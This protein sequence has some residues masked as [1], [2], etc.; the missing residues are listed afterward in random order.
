MPGF[1]ASFLLTSGWHTTAPFLLHEWIAGAGAW[2]RILSAHCYNNSYNS[3]A[4]M[5]SHYAR[6]FIIHALPTSSYWTPHCPVIP[7]WQ[8]KKQRLCRR[9]RNEPQSPH[10]FV[11]EASFTPRSLSQSWWILHC[12]L[13]PN[14]KGQNRLW[15]L[16]L[17]NHYHEIRHLEQAPREQ[18]ELTSRRTQSLEIKDP[19]SSSHFLCD[20]K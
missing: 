17:N 6:D 15:F 2:C 5:E 7:V 14:G 9:G 1:L 19:G 13:T 16:C 12:T 8:A 10:L 20:P 4:F 11:A 3:A 18:M